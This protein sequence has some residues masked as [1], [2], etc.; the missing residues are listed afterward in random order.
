MSQMNINEQICSMELAKRLKELGVKQES[1]FYRFGEENFQYIF[2]KEYEQYSPNVNLDIKDG[3][4]AFTA[5]E[6]FEMLP[7]SLVID[8]CLS[9]SKSKNNIYT[10]LYDHITEEINY[11]NIIV[12]D[13]NLSNCLAKILI[14]F[15]EKKLKEDV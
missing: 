5:A 14:C 3:Y 9:I 2:C 10:A 15:L 1:L 4:S 12:H 7:S 13:E 6:L 8:D 11:Y